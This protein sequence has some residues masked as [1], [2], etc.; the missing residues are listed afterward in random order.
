MK[1]IEA[2]VSTL[3]RA[4]SQT[5]VS[6]FL[7]STVKKKRERERHHRLPIPVVAHKLTL[8]QSDLQVA[9]AGAAGLEEERLQL[10]QVQMD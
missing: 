6:L 7:P 9:R 3:Q 10:Q 5:E 8:E 1:T 2:D 4:L